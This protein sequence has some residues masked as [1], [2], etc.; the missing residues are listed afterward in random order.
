VD[1]SEYF[2]NLR[3]LAEIANRAALVVV[4]DDESLKLVYHYPVN[5]VIPAFRTWLD[6]STD[7]KPVGAVHTSLGG[8]SPQ[9][10]PESRGDELIAG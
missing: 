8:T 10:S 6:Q 4:P 7:F 1:E 2:S 5:K 3:E 9:K